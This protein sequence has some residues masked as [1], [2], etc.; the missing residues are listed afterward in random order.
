MPDRMLRAFF[1]QIEEDDFVFPEDI[2]AKPVLH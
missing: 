1:E 2:E